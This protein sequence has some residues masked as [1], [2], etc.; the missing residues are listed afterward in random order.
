MN[1]LLSII[2][3]RETYT[4]KHH[5]TVL[6][7]AR[8]MAEKCIGAAAVLDGDRVVGVFS[9][10]DLMTRVVVPGRRADQTRV[11]EVMT[12]EIVM[13]HPADSYEEG[14]RRMQ[15]AKCRHLPVVEDGRLLGFV[16][17]RDLLEIEIEEKEEELKHITDYIHSAPSP[18]RQP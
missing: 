11:T 17:L 10:R 5:W 2:R 16:S 18:A 6:E 12:S 14:L 15:Q 7:A 3:G 1:K 4:L 13:G 8:Y 9:E